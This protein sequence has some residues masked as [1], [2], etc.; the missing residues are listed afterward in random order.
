[1]FE[2]DI[3]KLLLIVLLLAND[4][5]GNS[6]ETFSRLN[7]IIIICLLMGACNTS[8]NECGCGDTCRC[9]ENN[10]FNRPTSF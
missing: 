8:R 6:R 4:S 1:M 7:E 3:F 10:R 2:D 9:N 5:N